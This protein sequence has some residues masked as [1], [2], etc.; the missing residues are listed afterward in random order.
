MIEEEQRQRWIPSYDPNSE[1]FVDNR[2]NHN[3]LN[4]EKD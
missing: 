2:S 1:L 4:E 3:L